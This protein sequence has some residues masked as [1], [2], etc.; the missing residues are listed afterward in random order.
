MPVVE[1]AQHWVD[2]L[3]ELQPEATTVD[4]GTVVDVAM[5]QYIFRQRQE[6]I[7]RERRWYEA[8]HVELVQ[9]YR[10]RYIA[11]NNG[12]V[13]DDDGDGRVL[14]KRARQTYGR[15]AIAIIEVADTP[16]LPTLHIRSPKMATE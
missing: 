11:I 16:E 10:G 9:A 2:E 14:A 12:Q 4:L 5:K 8:H 3:T 6:K 15:T 1:L 13:V 7:A